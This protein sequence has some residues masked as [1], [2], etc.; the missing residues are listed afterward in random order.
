MLKLKNLINAVDR[1]RLAS[2]HIDPGTS[3]PYAM[4]LDE[5]LKMIK[6]SEKMGV[7]TWID[8]LSGASSTVI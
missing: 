4:T 3:N 5:A 1:L 8:L 7:G 6:S 2:Q